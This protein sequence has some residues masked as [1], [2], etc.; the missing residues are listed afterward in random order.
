MTHQKLSLLFSG[1]K[2]ENTHVYVKVLDFTSAQQLP[3]A[4]Q[5]QRCRT[6]K[7]EKPSGCTI[8][9]RAPAHINFGIFPKCG[10]S[11]RNG[12][13]C[14]E[15][16]QRGPVFKRDK[17]REKR[18]SVSPE[19]RKSVS[20]SAIRGLHASSCGPGTLQMASGMVAIA[21]ARTLGTL[22]LPPPLPCFLGSSHTGL[23]SVL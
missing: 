13:K 3:R 9:D 18:K 12:W 17:E 8:E 19:K 5:T 11:R 15:L 22:L 14:G 2:K 16:G 10:C 4:A 23:F 21:L 7:A 20:S 1:C 6:G